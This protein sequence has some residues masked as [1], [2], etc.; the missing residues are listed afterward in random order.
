MAILFFFL[1]GEELREKSLLFHPINENQVGKA[2][3]VL[4]PYLMVTL[5][6]SLTVKSVWKRLFLVSIILIYGKSLLKTTLSLLLFN[7]IQ[8]NFGSF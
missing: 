6:W 4:Y 2:C 7:A 5:D 8:T 1:L 3:E